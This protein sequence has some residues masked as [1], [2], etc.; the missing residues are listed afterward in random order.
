MFYYSKDEKNNTN[1]IENKKSD[2]NITNEF[3][4]NDLRTA[5]IKMDDKINEIGEYKKMINEIKQTKE[6]EEANI[7]LS[8][9][10]N[11]KKI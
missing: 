1:K 8:M 2:R 3:K 11:P 5:S 10:L 4:R 6:E 9:T 7:M